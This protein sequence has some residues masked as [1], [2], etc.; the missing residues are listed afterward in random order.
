MASPARNQSALRF[1]ARQPILT[2]D[3]QVIGYELLFRDSMVNH[4]S[5]PD[6]DNA[7]CSTLDSSLLM[8]LE[9][10]CNGRLA[11]LN[12][13][14]EVLLCDHALLFPPDRIVVEILETVTPDSEVIAA[15][16]RLKA[17]G[18]TLALD[19][20]GEKDPRQPLLDLAAFIKVDLRA[21]RPEVCAELPWTERLADV[22][23]GQTRHPSGMLAP[24]EVTGKPLLCRR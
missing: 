8:G 16:G 2:C 23:A 15:C 19:D 10:L 20:F 3:E 11:F 21:S 12:F 14:R 9:T 18:Y 5:S 4:F 22:A 1:V 6:V 7:A 17:A 24:I 13:T